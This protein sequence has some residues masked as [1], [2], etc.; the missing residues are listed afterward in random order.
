MAGQ[1]GTRTGP[2][3]VI[4]AAA[5]AMAAPVMAEAVG[6]YGQWGAFADG[7]RCHAITIAQPEDGERRDGYLS[8]VLTAKTQPQVYTRLSREASANAAISVT[9]EGRRFRLSGKG[10]DAFA[11]NAQM[12]KALIAA[13]RSARS[14]S[15]ETLGRDGRALVDSYTLS[16]AASAIDA[17]RLA[18]R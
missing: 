12:D 9:V 1:I 6:L 11:R 8:V 10:R 17:A 14:L 15:I 4:L 3:W 16:G 13:M 2:K 5:L 7:G 18:C